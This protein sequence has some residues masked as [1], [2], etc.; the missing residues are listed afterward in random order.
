MRSL[1]SDDLADLA[2]AFTQVLHSLA[3]EARERAVGG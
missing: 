1:L 2:K 3:A